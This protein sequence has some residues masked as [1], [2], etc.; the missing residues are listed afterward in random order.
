MAFGVLF[1]CVCLCESVVCFIW[2][3]HSSCPLCGLKANAD[4]FEWFHKRVL[5][6]PT[7][8]TFVAAKVSKRGSWAQ[9][10]EGV[11][12]STGNCVKGLHTRGRKLRPSVT[13]FMTR[14]A[15][16]FEPFQEGGR[17]RRPFN[18]HFFS[19]TGVERFLISVFLRL[20]VSCCIV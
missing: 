20:V 2:W 4:C 14:W 9:R 12:P 3:P 10:E 7:E 6:R 13:L 5:P 8:E 1:P 11:R 16:I 15:Q 18:Y 19:V 17:D